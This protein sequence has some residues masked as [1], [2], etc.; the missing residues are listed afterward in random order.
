MISYDTLY[1]YF[2][3]FIQIIIILIGGLLYINNDTKKLGKIILLSFGTYKFYI[4]K[5][6]IFLI[7]G[8]VLFS[9]LFPKKIEHIKY[10]TT[11]RD[12]SVTPPRR[13]HRIVQNN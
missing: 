7:T 13:S 8:L 4:I 12:R 2:V 11:N 9:I 3:Y 10:N 6:P 5:N 1:T